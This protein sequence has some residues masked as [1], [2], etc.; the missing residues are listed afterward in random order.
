MDELDRRIAAALR[1]AAPPAEVDQDLVTASVAERV[2]SS[3]GHARSRIRWGAFGVALVPLAAFTFALLAGLNGA[4]GAGG[5]G[6]GA[7][8]ER[9]G[10]IAVANSSVDAFDCPDGAVIGELLSGDRVLAV[11]RDATA[12]WLQVRDPVD[13]GRLLWVSAESVHA[14][15]GAGTFAGLPVAD[16]PL[17]DAL[18]VEDSST[19]FTGRVRDLESGSGIGGVQVVVT[20]IAEGQPVLGVV[21]T[22]ADGSYA[23]DGFTEEEYGLRVDAG[24]LAYE[25]G[26]VGAERSPNGWRVVPTFGDAVSWSPGVF[27]VAL[28][29]PDQPAEAPDEE[30]PPPADGDRPPEPGSELPPIGRPTNPGGPVPPPPTSVPTPLPTSPPVA[31]PPSIGTLTSNQSEVFHTVSCSP[32]RAT[33]TVNISAGAPLT[34]V[35]ATWRYTGSGPGHSGTVTLS[36]PASGGVWQGQFGPNLPQPVGSGNA[37]SIDV[38]AVDSQGRQS[39][40]SFAQVL[41]VQACIF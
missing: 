4:F 37:V 16:C 40:R 34:S 32:D 30:Q 17:V 9:S 27:D 26:W 6:G 13:I 22:D 5:D 19:A 29:R 21:V 25:S 41:V 23:L 39:E 28:G 10:P 24:D 31:V 33:L 3:T 7:P 8:A 36:G 38:R 14:D 35:T 1:A 12:S 18:P 15:E 20:S 11:G 2:A